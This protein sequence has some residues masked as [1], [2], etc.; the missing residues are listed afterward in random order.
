MG[1]AIQA[2]R[3]TGAGPLHVQLIQHRMRVS[4][5]CFCTMRVHS[6]L[7]ACGVRVQRTCSATYAAVTAC[8]LVPCGRGVKCA[9]KTF[10]PLQVLSW[11]TC[12]AHAAGQRQGPS[13][14]GRAQ[15]PAPAQDSDVP[16]HR[17]EYDRGAFLFAQQTLIPQPQDIFLRGR[18]HV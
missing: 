16:P 3:A 12:V 13:P 8:A 2:E 4:C 17:N 6:Y 14:R 1:L 5:V 9:I 18:L 15:G 10:L 7:R 11:H